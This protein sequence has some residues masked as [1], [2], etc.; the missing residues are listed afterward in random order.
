MLAAKH[1]ESDAWLIFFP[2]SFFAYAEIFGSLK[3][4]LLSFDQTYSFFHDPHKFGGVY[5]CGAPPDPI[6][7]SEV[8]T[9]HGKSSTEEARR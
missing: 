5:G 9:A 2:P 6:S 4:T 3:K 1:Y 8:K 7:N